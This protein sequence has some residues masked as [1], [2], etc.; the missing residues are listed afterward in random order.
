VFAH[1]PGFPS[2]CRAPNSGAIPRGRFRQAICI[3]ARHSSADGVEH[4]DLVEANDGAKRKSRIRAA[5]LRHIRQAPLAGDTPEGIVTCWL[6][7]HGYEDA[8]CFIDD[9]IAEMV[10]AGELAERPLPDG[11]VLYVRGAAVDHGAPD[12]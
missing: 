5:I 10:A 1:P 9:V 4:G 6:P 11:R 7:R 12:E 8:L 3:E 2:A